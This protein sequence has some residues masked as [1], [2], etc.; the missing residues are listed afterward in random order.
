MTIAVKRQGPTSLLRDIMLVEMN[1]VGAAADACCVA[2][3]PG[4]LS[5]KWER[6]GTQ[7][8]RR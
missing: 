5:R 1:M 3:F 6:V 2:Q 8:L 7:L 4:V